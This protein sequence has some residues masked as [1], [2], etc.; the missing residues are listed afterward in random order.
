MARVQAIPCVFSTA[1]DLP[2][3]SASRGALLCQQCSPSQFNFGRSYGQSARCSD[4]GDS[5]GRAIRAAATAMK[6]TVTFILIRRG[7]QQKLRLFIEDGTC[8]GVLQT[9]KLTAAIDLAEI[10]SLTASVKEAA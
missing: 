1:P 3:A 8:A 2:P 4:I 9:F 7:G 10:E 5:N 6:Y